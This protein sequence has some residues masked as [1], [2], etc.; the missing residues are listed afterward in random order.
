MLDPRTRTPTRRQTQTAVGVAGLLGFVLA[1]SVDARQDPMLAH[2][3]QRPL[4]PEV[5]PAEHG[6]GP[7]G[8]HWSMQPPVNAAD[9]SCTW[10]AGDH[11]IPATLDHYPARLGQ[12]SS[13]G[14]WTWISSGPALD[15]ALNWTLTCEWVAP[16]CTPEACGDA[17]ERLEL[18]A[19]PIIAPRDPVVAISY[20]DPVLEDRSCGVG[21]ELRL[22]TREPFD[23][24]FW[25]DGGVLRVGYADGNSFV[26][27]PGVT[28]TPRSVMTLVPAPTSGET[29]FGV[30]VVRGDGVVLDATRFDLGPAFWDSLI[31]A[32]RTNN[33]DYPP[34]YR[35]SRPRGCHRSG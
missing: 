11:Q 5:S 27:T 22:E 4:P 21:P 6:F 8:G 16:G 35:G 15:A 14:G 1:S 20:L 13:Q 12:N 32:D 33:Q 26:T 17:R 2:E 3:C 18:P 28:T 29:W 7:H 23:L 9:A 34:P 25:Q 31:V 24:G 19:R 30:E 10:A